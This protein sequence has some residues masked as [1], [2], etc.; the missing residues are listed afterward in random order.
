[1]LH[2]WILSITLTTFYA[3]LLALSVLSALL[4][5]LP[6]LLTNHALFPLTQFDN[7]A[8]FAKAAVFLVRGAFATGWTLVLAG[9]GLVGLAARALARAARTMPPVWPRFG[10]A[11]R[12]YC[13]VLSA[14]GT[15]EA[16]RSGKWCW[17]GISRRGRKRASTTDAGMDEPY[18][19]LVVERPLGGERGRVSGHS[20]DSITSFSTPQDDA[21][22][23]A[24][25]DDGLSASSSSLLHFIFR[26]AFNFITLY[27]F[28][29]IANTL[30]SLPVALAVDP[31]QGGSAASTSGTPF[32]VGAAFG[33]AGIAAGQQMQARQSAPP[34]GS[35]AAKK[36]KVSS[37]AKPR[38][39]TKTSTTL[40]ASTIHSPSTSLSPPAPAPLPF[41]TPPTACSASPHNPADPKRPPNL[42]PAASPTKP[43]TPPSTDWQKRSS[44]A[45]K[46]TTVPNMDGSKKVYSATLR[47]REA[48]LTDVIPRLEAKLGG[49]AGD[50]EAERTRLQDK[51]ASRRNELA[52]VEEDLKWQMMQKRRISDTA[53]LALDSTSKLS[54]YL[55]TEAAPLLGAY[56]RSPSRERST[57]R[58]RLDLTDGRNISTTVFLAAQSTWMQLHLSC[59]AMCGSKR[60]STC[61]LL[62]ILSQS[63]LNRFLSSSTSIVLATTAP[64]R[65]VNLLHLIVFRLFDLIF[66]EYKS[67]KFEQDVQND[68]RRQ[69]IDDLSLARRSRQPSDLSGPADAAST[70]E[71]K[72]NRHAVILMEQV[73]CWTSQARVHDEICFNEHLRLLAT[74]DGSIFAKIGNSSLS[75]LRAH[76]EMR[77]SRDASALAAQRTRSTAP[78]LTAPFAP[79]SSGFVPSSSNA[80]T[81]LSFSPSVCLPP[82]APA[83]ARPA[84]APAPRA[85]AGPAP[86]PTPPSPKL[87]PQPAPDAL[88]TEYGDKWYGRP[89]DEALGLLKPADAIQHLVLV[90]QRKGN[91]QIK[92]EDLP[93]SMYKMECHIVGNDRTMGGIKPS[94]TPPSLGFIRQVPGE[95]GGVTFAQ[96]FYS[97]MPFMG[98]FI[99]D[100]FSVSDYITELLTTSEVLEWA[101]RPS[102]SA[103]FRCSAGN[104]KRLRKVINEA[105]KVISYHLLTTHRLDPREAARPRFVVDTVCLSGFYHSKQ[106]VGAL[107]NRAGVAVLTGAANVSR[108]GYGGFGTVGEQIACPDYAS[109]ETGNLVVL[110]VGSTAALQLLGDIDHSTA[111]WIREGHLLPMTD[112]MVMLEAKEREDEELRAARRHVVMLEEKAKLRA[113]E[114]KKVALIQSLPKPTSL[115]DSVTSAF[116]LSEHAL[117]LSLPNPKKL[118]ALLSA[119]LASSAAKIRNLALTF[120]DTSEINIVSVTPEEEERRLRY[121]ITATGK[122]LVLRASERA[123]VSHYLKDKPGER[124]E[125]ELLCENCGRFNPCTMLISEIGCYNVTHRPWKCGCRG[126]LSPSNS[127]FF[128]LRQISASEDVGIDLRRETVES[129][130]ALATYH[131][132]TR[133]RLLDPLV[134]WYSQLDHELNT[135]PEIVASLCLF[136]MTD[137]PPTHPDRDRLQGLL[138]KGLQFRYHKL[139]SRLKRSLAPA[140]SV[141]NP[142]DDESDPTIKPGMLAYIVEYKFS[143]KWQNKITLEEA[144]DDEEHE[145]QEEEDDDPQ[146]ANLAA[147]P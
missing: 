108:Q 41:P 106:V 23:Y 49:L 36:R 97:M 112:E 26:F 43:F 66:E 135:Y 95:P 34:S 141:L 13:A 69:R 71:E 132:P 105:N 140:F 27:L 122:V 61:F 67:A 104:G 2:V 32:A 62:R 128:T 18:T 11:S 28:L 145:E 12:Y 14:G 143:K 37:T 113:R 9:N 39:K 35:P 56:A 116:K 84:P 40:A 139:S 87:A 55:W 24:A 50:A 44:S 127:T 60:T 80:S 111:F 142:G 82:S 19:P 7:F 20:N 109:M 99:M 126:K 15:I 8:N 103:L 6:I 1:M 92:D 42:H 91:S 76:S 138:A 51:I 131:A 47:D 146:D 75:P 58:C 30:S 83:P 65:L 94:N 134:R 16:R 123:R 81:F 31:T 48:K 46:R 88:Q 3:T 137:I 129:I 120:L 5:T 29:L 33:V 125:G 4:P 53:S 59:L 73:T 74:E 77:L 57:L 110:P 45:T 38:K 86:A 101:R 72:L 64:P 107:R 10:T 118:L 54:D 124:V 100:V 21:P 90:D 136:V 63:I 68:Q 121:P 85:A 114:A 144:N 22:A 17:G 119:P 102:S 89:L 117:K 98:R 147:W 79:T 96:Y 25:L 133:I 93:I 78:T 130:F 52:Q 70:L 115:L